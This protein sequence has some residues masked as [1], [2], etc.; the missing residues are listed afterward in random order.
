MRESAR[1]AFQDAERAAEAEISRLEKALSSSLTQARD[2]EAGLRKKRTKALAELQ[3]CPCCSRT[4]WDLL[5][6]PKQQ[7]QV[8]HS[9]AAP[10]DMRH[11]A[12]AP[13][14]FL[15]LGIATLPH[16][17][18]MLQYLTV[19]TECML[20]ACSPGS[21]KASWIDSLVH[22]R[23]IWGWF[24]QQ[25]GTMFWCHVSRGISGGR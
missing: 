15:P 20:V 10:M 11:A 5:Y 25:D 2:S 8:L 4:V 22:N 6:C 24:Q 14:T 1:L 19:A 17:G 12:D 16:W 3:V 21:S 9:D 23:G 13:A 7:E 18:K